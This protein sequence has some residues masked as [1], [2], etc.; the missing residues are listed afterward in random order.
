MKTLLMT[1]GVSFFPPDEK[2]KP[3]LDLFELMNWC[4]DQGIGFYGG[5]LV[6]VEGAI[7]TLV[8]VNWTRNF[9]LQHIQ[10]YGDPNLTRAFINEHQ[11]IRISYL[12]LLLPLDLNFIKDDRKSAYFFFNN[13]YIRVTKDGP[14]SLDYTEGHIWK[15]QIINHE[16][17]L[18]TPDGIFRSFIHNI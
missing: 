10:K 18:D 8:D 12:D 6:H 5:Q 11:K 1:E 3:K 4:N 17:N 9:I 16:I 13:G 15:N 2:G 14:E 7:V